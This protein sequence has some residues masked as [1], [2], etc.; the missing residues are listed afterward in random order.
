MPT[1]KLTDATINMVGAQS[2]KWPDDKAPHWNEMRRCIAFVKDH[3]RE[4][5][6]EITAIEKDPDLNPQGMVRKRSERAREA[7][8]K[9]NDLGL[10]HS[11]EVMVEQRV[12]AM[13]KKVS[14]LL[15]AGAPENAHDVL[16]AGEIRAYVAKLDE[17]ER[18]MF[19]ANNKD[20]M[21]TV[22]AVLNAPAFLSG[23]STDDQG[24]FRGLVLESADP[25][26][27]QQEVER[28]LDTCRQ[29]VRQAQT[30]I[31]ERA[32]LRRGLDGELRHSSETPRTVA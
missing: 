22:A 30:L 21:R 27:E 15:N 19:L 1:P 16:V 3:L 23:L 28:A 12:E 29:A 20:D 13:Q 6:Q 17:R 18:L 5:D 26:V 11:S 4:L 8:K 24:K 10:L 14:K 32:E 7:A 25:A 9:L 2:L 31:A